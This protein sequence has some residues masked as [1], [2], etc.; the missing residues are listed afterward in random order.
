MEEIIRDIVDADKQARGRVEQKQEE[1]LNIQN[2]IQD[3]SLE[4]KRRYQAETKRC[5][6]EKKFE[7]DREISQQEKK[8]EQLFEETLKTLTKTYEDH[9]EEWV[10][11]IVDRCLAS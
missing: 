9:R 8:E 3:Q 6:E 5:I 11:E 1:R 10:K 2:L 7:L 4:I